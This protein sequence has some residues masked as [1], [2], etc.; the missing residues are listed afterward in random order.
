MAVLM[1]KRPEGSEEKFDL[2]PLTTLGRHPEQMVQILDRVVSK[3]HALITLAGG[4]Y[5]VQ[6]RGSRNGTF[7]NGVKIQGRTPLKH[8][9]TLTLGSTQLRFIKLS[10]KETRDAFHQVTIQ[11]DIDTAIRSRLQA[12]SDDFLPER[13]LEDEAILRSDYEKLR[14]AFNLNQ[15]LGTE[16]DIDHLLDRIL[17]K[18]FEFTNA[19]RGA[20]LLINSE[21]VPEPRA[22]KNRR[23]SEKLALSQTILNEVIEHHYGLLSSDATIDS[24]FGAAQSIMM[25]GIR[26]TMCVPLMYEGQLL[27]LI[28]LDTRIATGVF[29]EKDLRILTVFANQA[30]LK[31]ANATLIKRAEDEAIARHN[32]SRLLS[33]NL[34]DAVVKGV[35]PMEEKGGE[36]RQATILYLDIRGFTAMTGRMRPQEMVCMLNEYFEIMVDIIFHFEGTLDKFIGDEI[37]AVWGA[38]VEQPRHLEQAMKAA[39]AMMRALEDFNR[40]REANG[41]QLIQAGCGLN[42]GS[43]VAGYMGSSQTLSYT[44]M[45]STVNLA[46]R[47]CSQARPGEILVSDAVVER[48]GEALVLE[49]L[50]PV[51]LKGI[52]AQVPIYRIEA[53]KE[54]EEVDFTTSLSMA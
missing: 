29:H 5:W 52:G 9:D 15:A 46:A 54:A 28:H 17:E 12:P 48:L 30:A 40:F 22:V 20:I 2:R 45:G 1:M 19:D 50:P 42:S 23:D 47:L 36:E 37:M 16:L 10:P 34:V 14:I 43:V 11:R 27:G 7:V 25:Q 26:S 21:G 33:P 38:P 41:E 51:A 13:E 39:L 32:L 18:A 49:P 53:F 3:E 35:I 24:R 4:K 6:D 8:E 44:V 31:I